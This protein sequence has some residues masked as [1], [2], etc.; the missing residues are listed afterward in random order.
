MRKA[1]LYDVVKVFLKP[2]ALCFFLFLI[3][4]FFRLVSNYFVLRDVYLN[5]LQTILVVL[6]CSIYIW[7]I[8]R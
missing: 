6:V 3:L 2:L 1:N 4:S 7:V 5:L 8:K